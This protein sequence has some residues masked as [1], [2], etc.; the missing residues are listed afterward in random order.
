MRGGALYTENFS[1]V[2]ATLPD[3]IPLEIAVAGVVSDI[4]AGVTVGR[5]TVGLNISGGY[6]KNLYVYLV[7]PNNTTVVLMNKP[8]VGVNR[9]GASGAGMNITLQDIGAAKW[10]HPKRDERECAERQL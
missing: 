1:G 8:G 3:G 10:Q 7:S 6:N 4:P 9:V 5:L 2:N